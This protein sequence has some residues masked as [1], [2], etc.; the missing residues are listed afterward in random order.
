MEQSKLAKALQTQGNGR[1]VQKAEALREQWAQKR[2]RTLQMRREGLAQPSVQKPRAKRRK[3]EPKKKRKGYVAHAVRMEI[4]KRD[5][6][7]CQ[8]CGVKGVKFQVDHVIPVSQGGKNKKNNLVTACIPC[9]LKK[10]TLIW[11]LGKVGPIDHH[12][13]NHFCHEYG[14]PPI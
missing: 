12:I 3:P 7:T 10:G 6:F 11:K 1:E 8:Y 5:H 13:Y 2:A 9:N 14:L 4:L